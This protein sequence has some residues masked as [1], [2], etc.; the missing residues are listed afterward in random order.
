MYL[1]VGKEWWM[2]QSWQLVGNRPS[3][4]WL[5]TH[6]TYCIH[7]IT[8]HS[9]LSYKNHHQYWIYIF[10]SQPYMPCQKCIFKYCWSW[11]CQIW[12]FLLGPRWQKIISGSG[13]EIW[14]RCN[15]FSNKK[16]TYPM[17]DEIAHLCHAVKR[18]KILHEY[19]WLYRLFN[20]NLQLL[21]PVC[22]VYTVSVSAFRSNKTE[23]NYLF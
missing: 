15:T 11:S 3:H 1:V 4:H 20:H 19:I 5:L 23:Q 17:S 14:I 21:K 9:I 12:A 13:L 10:C 8:P 2:V 6:P 22:T 16:L 18:G 7:H